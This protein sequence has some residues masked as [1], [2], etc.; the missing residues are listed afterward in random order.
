MT[1]APTITVTT[2][3]E[4]ATAD[5]AARLARRLSPGDL[6][7]L[8]GELGAGKTRF[9]R[10]LAIGL[11]IDPARVSSPTFVLA[12]VYDQA[13]ARARL[14][15]I[16]AY[17]LS[18]GDDIE[19]LGWDRLKASGSIVVVEWP[20]R[21]GDALDEYSRR[22]SVRFE[23]LGPDRRR[24]TIAAPVGWPLEGLETPG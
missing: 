4:E 13:G 8:S 20:E 3:G 14:V 12:N 1:T 22:I 6:V 19:S 17:R 15:H 5:L 7:T 21:L 10:G 16:D 11:G 23:H 18:G 2:I 9:V 24:L